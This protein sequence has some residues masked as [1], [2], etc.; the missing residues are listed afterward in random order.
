MSVDLNFGWLVDGAVA[1]S[2]APM[3]AAE[4]EYLRA[5]GVRAIVRLAHPDTDPLVMEH[6][7]VIRA[8]LEDLQIPV[9]DFHA[10]TLEQIES[11]LGFIR[12]QLRVGRP[13]AVSCGAGYGRTGTVLA[14][15]LVFGGMS[16][17]EAISE[18]RTKRPKSIETPEQEQAVQEFE[19]RFKASPVRSQSV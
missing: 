2:G 6:A 10:P 9:E 3:D 7:A 19:R 11:A 18:V 12:Q 5:E 4:L 17:S 8:G 15:H 16:A 13:V 1:G 14:C